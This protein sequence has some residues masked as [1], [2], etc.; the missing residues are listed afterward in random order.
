MKKLLLSVFTLLSLF[1]FAQNKM[2]PELL[3]KLGRVT[4]LGISKDGKYVLYSVS[5]PDQEANKSDKKSYIVPL[6]GG[7]P[8]EINNPDSL[9][10]NKKISPDG[11]YVL[12]NKEVKVKSILGSDKYKE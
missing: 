6:S 3:W 4:G 1:C 5:T 9:L 11:K 10:N 8:V 2:T 12:S 7:K